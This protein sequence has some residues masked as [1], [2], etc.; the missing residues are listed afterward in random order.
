MPRPEQIRDVDTLQQAA[1]LLEKTVISQQTTIAR[2]TAENA[3]LRGETVPAQL[4]LDLLKEQLE[5]L[6]KKVFA[7][8]SETR[9]H[10][11]AS[12]EEASK[13]PRRGHG[14]KA[15]PLL[16]ISTVTHTLLEGAR[17]C[18]VCQGQLEPMS[19]QS[20]DSEEITVIEAS[21]QVVTHRRQEYRCACNAAVVT[22]PGPAKLTAGGRYSPEFAVHV[23]EHKYLDHLP[24]ERQARARG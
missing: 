13:E 15:Q 23:A 2:L 8:S 24:R 21:Y 4:E 9:S 11:G 5:A 12:S 14:P 18:P 17:T 16:P 3:R 6:K 1:L 22:A 10:Q 20:E 7:P 19:E